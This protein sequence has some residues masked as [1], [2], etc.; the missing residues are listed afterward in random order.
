MEVNG[1]YSKILVPENDFKRIFIVIELSPTILKLLCNIL[2]CIMYVWCPTNV[3]SINANFTNF[4]FRF[5]FTL[6]KL[7]YL[8][9]V[10]IM[11][12]VSFCIYFL[13]QK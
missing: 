10:L 8:F 2:I 5:N 6:I 11:L 1:N 13:E 7:D 4:I 3:V 12:F 9:H